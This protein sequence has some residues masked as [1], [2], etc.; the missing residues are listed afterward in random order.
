MSAEGNMDVMIYEAN[1]SSQQKHCQPE[2]RGTEVRGNEAEKGGGLVR[3]YRQE[4]S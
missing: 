1:Q 3:F 4:E 2:L